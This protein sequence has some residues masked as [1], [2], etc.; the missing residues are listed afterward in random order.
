MI[1]PDKDADGLS[2]GAI[3]RHTL[4]LLGLPKDSIHVHLLAK[5][6]NVHSDH[7]RSNIAA[8]SPSYIFLV[9]LG[10]RAAPPIIPTEHVGLVIDHHHATEQDFPQNSEHITACHSPPVATSSL[11]TYHLCEALHSEVASKCDWLCIVSDLHRIC[12]AVTELAIYQPP[13]HLTGGTECI[14]HGRGSL[15]AP[16]LRF[17]LYLSVISMY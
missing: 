6:N 11:L 4:L 13:L 15:L 12:A 5:G 8:L 2:A 7:E 9:D 10:S 17:S 1:V 3:L 14:L 16:S